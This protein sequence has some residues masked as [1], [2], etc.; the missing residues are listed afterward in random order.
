[1]RQ[2]VWAANRN[3]GTVLQLDSKTGAVLRTLKERGGPTLP[4][5]PRVLPNALHRALRHSLQYFYGSAASAIAHPT[6]PSQARERT[7]SAVRRGAH[8]ITVPD[9]R[10][11]RRVRSPI[12]VIYHAETNSLFVGTPAHKQT[13]KQA[14]VASP[15]DQFERFTE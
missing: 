9:V 1:M 12:G 6:A 4:R 8:G 13:N 14:E 7:R 5:V 2:T 11:T 10:R 3:S 15:K